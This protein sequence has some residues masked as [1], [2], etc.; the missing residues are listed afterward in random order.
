MQSERLK[1]VLLRR[2]L[3]ETAND[4]TQRP[5]FGLWRVVA[6]GFSGVG[7]TKLKGLRVETARSSPRQFEDELPRMYE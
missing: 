1:L 2:A 5:G 3:A 6:L 4:A 7:V